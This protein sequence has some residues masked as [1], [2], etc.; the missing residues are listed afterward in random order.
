MNEFQGKVVIIT[1]ATSG[2][3]AATAKRFA[4]EGA[5]VILIG[6]NENKGKELEEYIYN[7]GGN[8]EFFKCDVSKEEEVLLTRK[9]IETKYEGV[10]VLFNNAGIMLQS[11]EIERLSSEEW[12][13][14][15]ETNLDSMF[16][17][18]KQFK[19]MLFEKKGIIINNASIAG[20]HTYVEGRSYAYS[21]SKSAVIQFT[22]QMAKNYAEEG[23][24]VNCICPGII[25]TPILGDRDREIYA[26]RI[27]LG[28]VGKPLEVAE[29]VIFLAS[30]KASYI[31]GAVIP[32]DGG[33]SL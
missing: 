7:N 15:F 27:P 9:A 8:A 21:A 6:R 23:V 28:Y 29:I 16:Y 13:T 1:G 22:R 33:V 3:G 26:K 20:M 2:I 31:T 14:T 30:E 11:K 18:T 17:M 25:E 4:I 19:T 24:R 32:I 10:D 5:K 12:K